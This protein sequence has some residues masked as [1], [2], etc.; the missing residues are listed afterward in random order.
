VDVAQ[1]ALWLVLAVIMVLQC[2]DILRYKNGT[3]QRHQWFGYRVQLASASAWSLML[4]LKIVQAVV[5]PSVGN[6]VVVPLFSG[7]VAINIWAVRR[8][9]PPR[10]RR[11]KRV[12][13]RVVDLGHRLAVMPT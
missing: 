9:R 11:P 2:V 1:V 10:K 7:T 4:I 6:W 13:G 12:S 5:D 8:R 3:W